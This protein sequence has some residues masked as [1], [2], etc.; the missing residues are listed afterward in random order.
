MSHS[1]EISL[2]FPPRILLASGIK[3]VGLQLGRVQFDPVSKVFLTEVSGKRVNGGTSK[4]VNGGTS[5][6]S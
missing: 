1:C 5:K 4:G 6:G 2:V 3:V